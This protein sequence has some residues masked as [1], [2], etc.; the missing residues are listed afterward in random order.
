MQVNNLND[1]DFAFKEKMGTIGD[2]VTVY[3]TIMTNLNY[4]HFIW[5]TYV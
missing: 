5:G 2:N 4:I 1:F 3:E